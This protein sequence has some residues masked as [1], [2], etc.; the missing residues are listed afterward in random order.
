MTFH[1]WHRLRELAHVRLEW[2]DDDEAMGH[3]DFTCIRLTL[4][5][6]QAERRCTLTH[7][8][9]HIE[10]GPCEPGDEVREEE[11]VE[12]LAARLL[13]DMRKLAETLAW[14]P[15]TDSAAA[16]LWVDIPTLQARLRGLH[17]S[18]RAYLRKRLDHLG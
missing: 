1:P 16:E 6:T 13:I 9:V 3:T 12:R 15:D 11:I 4:G 8:L 7:E 5:M 2:V 10:R 18:E 14:A 17:P